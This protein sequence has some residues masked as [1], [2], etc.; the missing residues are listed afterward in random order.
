MRCDYCDLQTKQKDLFKYGETFICSKCL[1]LQCEHGYYVY[2]RQEE[3]EING[4]WEEN[5]AGEELF[6]AEIIIC[7]KCSKE[8]A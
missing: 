6:D 1:E 7:P 8:K 5:E 2:P 3:L 4:T